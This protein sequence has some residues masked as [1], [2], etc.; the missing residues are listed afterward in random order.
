MGIRAIISN[1]RLV[2]RFKN[3]RVQSS[4]MNISSSTRNHTNICSCRYCKEE[5]RRSRNT[6]CLALCPIIGIITLIGLI[7]G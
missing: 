5:R 2:S 3:G 6:A 1:N 4:S 7:T